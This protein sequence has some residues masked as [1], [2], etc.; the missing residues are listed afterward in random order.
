M[1]RAPLLD[2]VIREG[3][4]ILKGFAGKDQLLRFRIDAFLDLNLRLD[5]LYAVAGF[6]FQRDRLVVGQRLDD[7]LHGQ[8]G[9]V[10]ACGLVIGCIAG[11]I[12]SRDGDSRAAR[13]HALGVDGQGFG[14]CTQSDLV[15]RRAI[16]VRVQGHAAGGAPLHL[17]VGRV[18]GLNLSRKGHLSAHVN[19]LRLV[20]GEGHA[21][22]GD[23]GHRNIIGRV[24]VRGSF[25][26]TAGARKH[27]CEC[28][29]RRS[30]LACS[31]DPV[32]G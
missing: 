1:E 9:H 2:V 29:S 7:N 8:D 26:F 10:A 4:A 28:I 15:A 19:G 32:F 22:D 23:G 20:R 5:V 18:A 24:D 25:K 30:S 17:F 27:R 14:S 12:G 11:S 31:R 3:A 6:H 13:R 16:F 21:G